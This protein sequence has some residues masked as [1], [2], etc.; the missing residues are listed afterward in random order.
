MFI[1]PRDQFAQLKKGTMHVYQ[2][3]PLLRVG[4]ETPGRALRASELCSPRTWCLPVAKPLG[5]APW[6]FKASSRSAL[7]P[8]K[9]PVVKRAFQSFVCQHLS[10][11][12]AHFQAVACNPFLHRLCGRA[13]VHPR[14]RRGA[15]AWLPRCWLHAPCSAAGPARLRRR[16]S[17]GTATHLQLG[18]DPPG[19]VVSRLFFFVLLSFTIE[20]SECLVPLAVPSRLPQGL[21]ID[22]NI[23]GLGP[24][25]R[26]SFVFWPPPTTQLRAD[27]LSCP[28][29][30]HSLD[31]G[32]YLL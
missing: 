3:V 5:N 9:S 7:S 8:V 1:L 19:T 23:G 13:P 17:H 32:C 4:C 10:A 28:P 30:G 20:I 6:C 27:P 12:A 25:H 26:G 16:G 22:S 15:G 21:R 11:R 31:R 18:S 29:Q 24:G 14:H 2:L